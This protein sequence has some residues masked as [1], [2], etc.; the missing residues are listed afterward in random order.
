MRKL[1]KSKTQVPRRERNLVGEAGLAAG[2]SLLFSRLPGPLQTL[3][4]LIS[5]R[6]TNNRV[7][8]V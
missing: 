1:T 3:V 6:K 5:P 2:S 4:R 7:F 8:E